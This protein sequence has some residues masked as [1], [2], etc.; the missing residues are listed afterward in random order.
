MTRNAQDIYELCMGLAHNFLSIPPTYGL[1]IQRRT[2]HDL[3][4]KDNC[5]WFNANSPVDA[6]LKA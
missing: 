1:P 6:L 3:R 2:D 4:L 5:S